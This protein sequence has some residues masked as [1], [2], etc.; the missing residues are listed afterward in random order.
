MLFHI[1]AAILERIQQMVHGRLPLWRGD[2]MFTEQHGLFRAVGSKHSC[3]LIREVTFRFLAPLH[4]DRTWLL[5]VALLFPPFTAVARSSAPETRAG[6]C[7]RARHGASFVILFF[8]LRSKYDL[9]YE[10]PPETHR[11][12]NRGSTGVNGGSAIGQRVRRG[13]PGRGGGCT[14]HF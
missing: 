8:R 2:H 1:R 7:T 3:W 4:A 13:L 6:S 9:M 11:R 10:A 14:E 12:V 5:S